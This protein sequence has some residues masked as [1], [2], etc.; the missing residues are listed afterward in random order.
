MTVHFLWFATGKRSEPHQCV[1]SLDSVHFFIDSL[2]V[3]A[4]CGTEMLNS[5]ETTNEAIELGLVYLISV[6][7]IMLRDLQARCHGDILRA[8]KSRWQV[9][10][11]VSFHFH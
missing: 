2:M 6:C 8:G 10:Y 9:R 4:W 5:T 1:V 7:D 3:T 11:R